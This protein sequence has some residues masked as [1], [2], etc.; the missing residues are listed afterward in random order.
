MQSCMKNRLN[1]L[2]NHPKVEH[3]RKSA[4]VI[5]DPNITDTFD[6]SQL[7]AKVIL[8]LPDNGRRLLSQENRT[9]IDPTLKKIANIF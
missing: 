6:Y 9:S 5:Y 7:G 3:V 4:I 8:F 2:E 1:K